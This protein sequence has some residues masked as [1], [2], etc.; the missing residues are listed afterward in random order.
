LPRAGT[1]R[2]F[3][4]HRPGPKPALE[5][6]KVSDTP[7]AERIGKSLPPPEPLRAHGVVRVRTISALAAREKRERKAKI[8]VF[9]RPIMQAIRFKPLKN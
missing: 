6:F 5:D 1:R 3:T 7:G 8:P 4:P 9:T 2:V